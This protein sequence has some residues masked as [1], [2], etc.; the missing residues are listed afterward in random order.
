MEEKNNN[1]NEIILDKITR[2]M[3]DGF[4]E[5]QKSIDTVLDKFEKRLDTKLE[6]I[7]TSIQNDLL[8]LKDEIKAVKSDTENIRTEL[9]KKIDRFE[10]KELEFRVE[11][12]EKKFA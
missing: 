12:L 9:N 7:A 4:G 8:N 5:M 3:S 10:H 2:K 11:K 1:K 6:K